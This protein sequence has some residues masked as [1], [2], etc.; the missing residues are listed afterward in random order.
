[1]LRKLELSGK[2]SRAAWYGKNPAGQQ[3]WENSNLETFLPSSLLN[4][5]GQYDSQ[6]G[7]YYFWKE[8]TFVFERQ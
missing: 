4:Q 6:F 8:T 7:Y 3:K 5:Q 2:A 1:M